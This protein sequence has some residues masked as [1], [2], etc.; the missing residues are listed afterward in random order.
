MPTNNTSNGIYFTVKALVDEVE[1]KAT[2]GTLIMAID[3][4]NVQGIHTYKKLNRQVCHMQR[5]E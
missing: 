2:H 1:V 3:D 4:A 5:G